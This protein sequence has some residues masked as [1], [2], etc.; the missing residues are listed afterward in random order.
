MFK[1]T[2]WMLND[3]T[4][5]LIVGA[6]QAFGFGTLSFTMVMYLGEVL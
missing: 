4:D 1:L 2:I 5:N 6:A 3:F